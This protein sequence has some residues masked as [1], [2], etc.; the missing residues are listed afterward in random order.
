MAVDVFSK[1]VA[2]E[3]DL[4][5]KNPD[6]SPMVDD[7]G[8]PSTATVWSPGTKIWQ[9]AHAAMRRKAI[10]RSREAKGKYEA[11][12]DNEIEDQVEFLV[13]ITRRF[14]NFANPEGLEPKALVERVYNDMLLGYIRDHMLEDTASWENFMKA[15]QSSSSSGSDNM[16]G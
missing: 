1:R 8:N 5:V 2:A 9:V 12:L 16:P 13:A 14:N 10:K 15:S 11:A 6:N 7:E 4:P 3:A